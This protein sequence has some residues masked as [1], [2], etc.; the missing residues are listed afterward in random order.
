[1]LFSEFQEGENIMG[2]YHQT[3]FDPRSLLPMT[4]E[5]TQPPV[6]LAVRE[7]QLHRLTPT[8]LQLLRPRRLHSLFQ[9]LHQLLVLAPL[10]RPTTLR[11]A[12]TADDAGNSGS[13]PADNDR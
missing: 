13:A 3:D 9:L 6:F 1:V 12:H 10:D 11:H 2:Q 8:L 4:A 7:T 5:T